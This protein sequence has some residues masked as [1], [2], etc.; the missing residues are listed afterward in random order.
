MNMFLAATTGLFSM[1]LAGAALAAPVAPAKA[2][3]AVLA[4]LESYLEGHRTGSR[5]AFERAFHPQ[6]ELFGIRE[7]KVFR[8]TAAQYAARAGSGRASPDDAQ[9]VRTI[10]SVEVTGGAGVAKI[11]LDYPTVRYT[12]YMSLLLVD[13]RWVIVNK[14]FM[15]EAKTAAK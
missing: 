8:E 15:G 9:R 13:G 10:E 11:V 3:P 6:A 1:A 14:T 2:D 12:D 7:G 4:P 5:E